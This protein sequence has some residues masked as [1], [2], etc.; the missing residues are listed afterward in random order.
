[1][2]WKR[3]SSKTSVLYDQKG[4]NVLYFFILCSV[5]IIRHEHHGRS[6]HTQ[7]PWMLIHTRPT[8]VT[9][10]VK[11]IIFKELRT[12]SRDDL[13]FKMKAN[14]FCYVLWYNLCVGSSV[15]YL[16]LRKEWMLLFPDFYVF[17]ISLM[18][19]FV[20]VFPKYINIVLFG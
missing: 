17:F 16:S 13:S 20:D 5:L 3:S 4:L 1:M 6:L 9:P 12:S 18:L 15:I 14:V 2:Q 11:A 19:G 8:E 10:W 7:L